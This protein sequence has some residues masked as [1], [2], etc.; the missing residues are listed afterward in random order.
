MAAGSIGSNGSTLLLV[1][2]PQG[3]RD[4]RPEHQGV[5]ADPHDHA[6]DVQVFDERRSPRPVERQVGREELV[7]VDASESPVKVSIGMARAR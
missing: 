4:H 3:D 1:H 2:P 5:A 7:R 6:A